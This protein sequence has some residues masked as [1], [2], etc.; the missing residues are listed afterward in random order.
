[1]KTYFVFFA[2]LVILSGAF[3]LSVDIQ[4]IPA[5]LQPGTSG[6]MIVN[7]TNTSAT[8][9]TNLR[10]TIED[11]PL[12][13]EDEGERQYLDDV[14][15]GTVSYIY[16]FYVPKDLKPGVY[17]IPITIEYTM[18]GETYEEH[19]VQLVTIE[20][21]KGISVELPDK[22]YGERIQPIT[23][24]VT[25]TGAPLYSA[26]LSIPSALGENIIFLGDLE[27]GET[28]EKLVQILPTCQNGL[29]TFTL[30]LEGYRGTEYVS[31][32]L[33][34]TSVCVPPS[35]DLRVSMDIPEKIGGGEQNTPL[36]IRNTT[37]I[38][39]GPVSITITGIN[40]RIG[41]KTSYYFNAIPPEGEVVIPVLWKL[42]KSDEAGEIDVTIVTPS[43][44]RRYSFSVL[45]S[46]QPAISVYVNDVPEWEG[47]LVK[48]VLSVAN[49]GSGTA[50]NVFVETNTA[51]GGKQLIGDLAPGDYDTV[52][53]YLKNPKETAT[54]HV[55][56]EYSAY[57]EKHI[58]EK[59][60]T[61]NVPPKP[62]DGTLF[63]L[64]LL[65]AGIGYYVW[66]RRR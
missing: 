65:L 54:I 42:E 2:F 7:I 36:R 32:N 60:I 9:A 10:L 44:E 62:A 27:S 12:N 45:P 3:A 48:I 22:V 16:G 50:E 43:G 29:Y 53:V 14:A 19:F 38:P 39:V 34:Y 47:D 23:V 30:T 55:T 25:N 46:D 58:E 13:V 1:M 35:T 37:S 52:T 18:G 61:V 26:K 20:S 63:I 5:V 17:A 49:V 33:S 6:K 66:R 15:S 40:V 64:L 4:T 56:V 41:G 28:V 57:G 21:G 8:P 11:N 59:D 31:E 51:Y 24:K